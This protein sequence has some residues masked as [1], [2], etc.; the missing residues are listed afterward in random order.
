MTAR[1]GACLC[2][3]V[4]ISGAFEDAVAACHCRQCQT[5]TGGGPLYSVMALG[6][7][8]ITGTEATASYKAS[9]W[10]E[11]VFCRHCG[12]TLWWK[13]QG[14]PVTSVA[15]GLFAGQDGLAVTS[16]IFVDCRAG[17]MP[18]LPGTGQS[19][20]AEE[21]AKLDVYLKGQNT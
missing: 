16:E 4:R 8:E 15:P 18:P 5:W 17:W 14:K 3:A 12:T 9:D 2:G 10:G 13:M 19:T 11:R 20:Q 21:M 7:V 1:Q 6:T